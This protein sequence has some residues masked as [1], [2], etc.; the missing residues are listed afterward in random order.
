MHFAMIENKKAEAVTGVSGLCPGCLQPVI[1]K[2]GNVRIHHWA[3]RSKKMCDSWWEPETEWHRSW[4]NCF[5]NDWQEVFLPDQETGEK[6]IAD[7]RTRHGIVIEFQH[8][9]IEPQERIKREKFYKNM[10]WVVDGTRLKRDYPRFIKSMKDKIIRPTG[11]KGSF[12][13]DFPDECFPVNW[14]ESHVPVIFDFRGI[15]TL[16]EQLDSTK[17]ILWC[18]LPGRANKFAILVTIFRNDFISTMCSQSQLFS[19]PVQEIVKTFENNFR[20]IKQQYQNQQLEYLLRYSRSRVK[21]NR[22]F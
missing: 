22:R 3:H 14:I 12:Y 2:C 17:D 20:Q 19:M 16:S 11:I 1:A 8:S 5:P 15:T 7:I 13:V 6:H 18:L 4:K 21:R 10:V 9:H